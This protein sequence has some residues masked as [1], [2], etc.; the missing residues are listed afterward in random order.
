MKC[1]IKILVGLA[2]SLRLGRLMEL[3][4][5]GEKKRRCRK[6]AVLGAGSDFGVDAT[7]HNAGSRPANIQIGRNSL[8]DGEL[9]IHDYGGEIRIG[10]N[11]YIGKGSRVWSGERVSIGSNV[12]VAH[13]VN[14]TDTN[15]HQLSAKERAAHW[16]RTYV[17]GLPFEKAGVE[18]A[19]IE[20]AD[21][22][23]I[24]FNVGILKGVKIGEGAIVGAGC[25]V[26][27]DVPPYTLVAG[28]PMRIIKELKRD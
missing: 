22:V 18:T 19:A 20:I 25:L 4:I 2:V 6:G 16:Q 28:N 17:S 1:A 21:H 3:V 11:T 10:N 24:N 8:V 7:V 26:N 9:L 12:F 27:K 23:W 14:I 15:S 5:E 13:N